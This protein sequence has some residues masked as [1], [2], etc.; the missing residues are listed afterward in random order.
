MTLQEKILTF[1]HS[2]GLSVSKFESMC[3]FCNGYVRGI[4]DTMG[5][6][7]L[8]CILNVFPNLSITWLLYDLGPMIVQD[9]KSS[10]QFEKFSNFQKGKNLSNSM[11][12]SKVYDDLLDEIKKKDEYIDRMLKM[13]EHIVYNDD[14]S[15]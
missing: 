4:K 9:G 14:S 2:E 13:L 6:D 7:K 5:T 8:T 12:S 11:G 15:L 10:E 1:I 3:G